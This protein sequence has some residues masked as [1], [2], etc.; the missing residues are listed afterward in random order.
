MDRDPEGP[1]LQ[2]RKREKKEESQTHS[3]HQ[4][5]ILGERS[6]WSK[7]WQGL[8]SSKY[9][10]AICTF[11]KYFKN[12]QSL[13]CT[14]H[15]ILWVVHVAQQ[16]TFKCI[17]EHLTLHGLRCFSGC[18]LSN[19]LQGSIFCKALCLMPLSPWIMPTHPSHQRQRLPICFITPAPFII[20]ILWSEICLSFHSPRRFFFSINSYSYLLG[21]AFSDSLRRCNWLE[22]L[23]NDCC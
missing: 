3:L 11:Q 18:P 13:I 8:M 5:L 1:N 17:F 12:C 22:I 21:E 10:I 15:L 16:I 9:H 20:F 4:H 7:Q 19:V 6:K 2:N 23:N 14:Q